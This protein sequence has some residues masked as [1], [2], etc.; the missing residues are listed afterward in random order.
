MRRNDVLVTAYKDP[1][2]DGVACAYGY[3][4]LLRKLG[5]NAVAGVSGSIDLET[6]FALREFN[7]S[8]LDDAETYIRG[9]ARII[10]VDASDLRG[11]SNNIDPEKVV[12]IIDHRVMNE[13]SKFPNANVQIEF[14]GSAATLIAERFRKCRIGP[15]MSAAALLYSAIA[16]NTVNFKANVTTD[17]DI[18][19]AKWCRKF[20]LLP[21]QYVRRMFV[22]KSKVEATYRETTAL[23][24]FRFGSF[25]FGIAQLEICQAQ[26]FVEARVLEIR[27]FLQK[28]KLESAVET[29]FFSF[30]DVQRK[31]NVVVACDASAEQF[32]AEA[33]GVRFGAGIGTRPGILMRKEIVPLIRNFVETSASRKE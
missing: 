18:R 16:S 4:E 2:L 24:T 9:G 25:S 28:K 12:E 26:E 31:C 8:S 1:D 27:A 5:T 33:L 30:V 6:Q 3:A 14:V 22:A 19:L 29:C 15:S 20:F 11:L 17:R 21:K 13:A 32:L 23:A 7:I 10:I